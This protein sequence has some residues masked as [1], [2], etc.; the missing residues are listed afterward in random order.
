MKKRV[1]LFVLAIVVT[2]MI[3][4]VIPV[5]AYESLMGFTETRYWDKAHAYN[6]YTLFA[7]AGNTYLVDMEGRVAHSWK[8]GTNPKLLENGD[9]LDASRDDP[10][11]FGGFQEM[12]WNGNVV[13]KYTETRT[14]YHPHHDFLRIFNPKLN[15]YTTL[16][17]ANKDLTNDQC[18]AAGCDPK[19]APY[20]GAQMDTIVEVDM[21]GKIVWE[22]LFFDHVIQDIDSTKSNYVGAVKTIADYPGRLN[23]NLPGHSVSKDWLHCNSLDYNQALDQIVIN[24]VQ[25]EFYV[26]D[27]GR[28][29]QSGDPASSIRLA[30]SQA[31]DFLYRFGDPA[32]YKQG[33]PP[34]ISDNWT[35][36]TTGT[37]Q[38]GGS[39]DIQWIQPGLP[40]AGHFLVFNN[41]QY[42]FERT[43]QS[44][45]VEINGYLNAS[46]QDT[47]QY[48]NPPAADYT[49]LAP[50][51]EKDTHKLPKKI[52]NQVVWT[53]SSKSNVAFFNHIGG[54]AQRL[55]NGNTLI[56]SDT[57]GQLFEVTADGTVVWEYINP[58]IKNGSLTVMMDNLPMTNSVF[59]AYRFTTDY[60][61]LAGKTLTA[62]N[63]ITSRTPDYLTPAGI[64]AGVQTNGINSGSTNVSEQNDL[65]NSPAV[66]LLWLSGGLG[67]FAVGGLAGS[68]LK[69]RR[70]NLVWGGILVAA[71]LCSAWGWRS[72]TQ[73]SNTVTPT[74]D[75]TAVNAMKQ[76]PN[77]DAAKSSTKSSGGQQTTSIPQQAAS[78]AG[79]KAV[80]TDLTA[81]TSGTCTNN[82]SDS[83]QAKDCCDCLPG[84]DASAIK[85][86]RD[87]ATNHDFSQN[88]D[89]ITFTAPS[90]LG[91]N[92]DYSLFTTAGNQQDCKQLCDSS[93]K[94]A[95]GDRRFCRDAC[96]KLPAR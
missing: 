30:A 65:I 81:L 91:Q 20:N 42:L 71:V 49:L 56:C 39:H 77:S 9:L 5:Q 63:T 1:N 13:W 86:C 29:F 45:I 59:R 93:D 44:Y 89:F 80:S 78:K 19:H 18:I 52:S 11:G 90:T 61:G 10:S 8:M 25:G 51:D 41:G 66:W 6:G 82:T 3:T 58:A 17:I 2:L 37:K 23:L 54:S 87:A 74:E 35:N 28:T 34:S 57:E 16:Y 31:G 69:S 68:G 21:Q 38:I 12:D 85:T 26:I 64:V 75:T 94:L 73:Q 33:D 60:P 62:K 96:D 7:G 15:A 48:V 32:L 4:N 47:S 79:G 72:S 40:G 43:P 92:G 53:Y 70:K 67:F 84:T 27:H 24:S 55:P 76:T 95:C 83:G 22:W 50:V 88:S 36:S 14:D 46:K